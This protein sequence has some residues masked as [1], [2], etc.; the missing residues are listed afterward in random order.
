MQ[1][2]KQVKVKL[3]ELPNRLA[4]ASRAMVWNIQRITYEHVLR[5]VSDTVDGIPYDYDGSLKVSDLSRI[6]EIKRL[7]RYRFGL[8]HEADGAVALLDAISEKLKVARKRLRGRVEFLMTQSLLRTLRLKELTDETFCCSRFQ[9]SARER[10]TSE[11]GF[12]RSLEARLDNPDSCRLHGGC[13]RASCK[14]ARRS[15]KPPSLPNMCLPS[16][17]AFVGIITS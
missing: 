5:V 14:A 17:K 15:G 7:T 9:V 4:L 8:H 16:G 1:Q 13:A 3:H 2:E 12:S 10:A 6:V 11:L